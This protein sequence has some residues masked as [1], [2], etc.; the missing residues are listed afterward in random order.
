[1]RKCRIFAVILLSMIMFE[2]AA[3]AGN[4]MSLPPEAFLNL[5]RQRAALQNSFADMRGKIT[6]LRRNQGGARYYPLRFLIRFGKEK[7][8]AKLI[9]NGVEQHYFERD[10]W[11]KRKSVTK[12]EPAD[13]TL[14]EQLGFRI[15]DLAMEFLDY[16]VKRELAPETLKTVHCRVL[17]LTAPDGKIVKVWISSEYMFPLKAEFFANADALTEA[18][19]R[20]LEITGFKKID[21]YYVASDIA[22]FCADFRSRVTFDQCLVQNAD[23]AQLSDE[24]DL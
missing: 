9:L 2:L 19:L 1:M 10:I 15:G 12:S 5:S 24:F 4:N 23:T 16:P 14:L 7:V 6:H 11:L 3:A 22:L 17:L 20:S 18:P 8:Q 13:N 21:N